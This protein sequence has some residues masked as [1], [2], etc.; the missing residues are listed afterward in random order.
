[1]LIQALSE[2]YDI[3]SQ[4]GKVVADEYS[5]VNINYIV[6]LTEDG[7]ID[8]LIE[9]EKNR[10]EIMPKKAKRQVFVQILLNTGHYICLD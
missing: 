10:T 8:N 7:K 5:E 1:M 4:E 2:Y 6:C 3:L 9:C